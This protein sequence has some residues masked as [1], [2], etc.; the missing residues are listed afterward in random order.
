MPQATT[1]PEFYHAA[2]S[3]PALQLQVPASLHQMPSTVAAGTTASSA[4]IVSD[5]YQRI[6]VA[7]TSSQAGTLSLQRYLDQA[8]SIA[9][10]AAISASLSANQPAVINAT[11]GLPFQSLVVSVA[12]SGSA[13][14]SLSALVIL[15]Q[16]N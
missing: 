3:G 9:Q 2:A 5:G 10:G 8:G 15:L 16:G 1:L 13:G 11:D 7:V 14:A 6:A 4:V 12:N